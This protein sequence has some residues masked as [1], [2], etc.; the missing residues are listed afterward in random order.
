MTPEKRWRESGRRMV[1]RP[2]GQEA[3]RH[4]QR[5]LSWALVAF[6]EAALLGSGTQS[7]EFEQSQGQALVS[8]SVWTQCLQKP[9]V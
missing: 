2:L 1:E 8:V 7:P 9:G 4:R 5:Q 6:V 3:E